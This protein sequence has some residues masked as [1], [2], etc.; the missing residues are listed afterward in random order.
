MLKKKTIC[1]YQA[2]KQFR[3]GNRASPRC[4]QC[5]QCGVR[6]VFGRPRQFSLSVCVFTFPFSIFI[7]Q[8]PIH[9]NIDRWL[10]QKSAFYAFSWKFSNYGCTAKAQFCRRLMRILSLSCTCSKL[11]SFG[12]IA[13]QQSTNIIYVQRKVMFGQLILDLSVNL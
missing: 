12:Q 1:F 5:C 3:S 7:V 6:A 4:I 13:P 8:C 10:L 9:Q 11:T 2:L